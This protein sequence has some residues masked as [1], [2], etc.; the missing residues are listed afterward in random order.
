VTTWLIDKSALV[1]LVTSPDEARK[2]WHH[3]TAHASDL[4]L[5]AE[6]IDP[7][8]GAFLGNTPQGLSHLAMINAAVLLADGT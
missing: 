8:T 7:A 1:R 4:G 6:Q 3:L 5:Y 2:L